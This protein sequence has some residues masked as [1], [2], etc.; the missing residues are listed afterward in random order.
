MNLSELH[1]TRLDPDDQIR[2]ECA[3]C[4]KCCRNVENSVVVETL[5]LFRL[6]KF[7]R[8]SMEDTAAQYTVAVPLTES[9]LPFLMLKTVGPD[10]ACVF[11]Q[12][13]SC[14]AQNAKLRACRLYPF[15][16]EPTGPGEFT[17]ALVAQETHHYT[18]APFR[19]GDWF[20]RYF[21]EEDRAFVK[22]DFPACLEIELCLRRLGKQRLSQAIFLILRYKYGNFDVKKDFLPQ[23]IRNMELL[24]REL[25]KLI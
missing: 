2:F 18:G 17:P 4:G 11:Y 23:F 5:D 12:N 22:L 7:L 6:A 14:A 19:V 8:K 21:T 1:F 20:D 10:N 25:K 24:K 16:A 15:G 9:G 3:R 13:G